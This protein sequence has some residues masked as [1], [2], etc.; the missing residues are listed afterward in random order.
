M[1]RSKW[2][3][4]V[5]LAMALVSGEVMARSG[6]DGA[7]SAA[8][9][10]YADVVAVEPGVYGDELRAGVRLEHNYLITD[11]GAERLSSYPLGL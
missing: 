4:S 9:L 11:G 7:S 8:Y 6:Y 1:S 2:I 3:P 5:M 10:D